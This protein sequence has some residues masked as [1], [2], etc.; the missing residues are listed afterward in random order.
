MMFG[1]AVW[2]STLQRHIPPE[3]LSRVSAYDWFGSLA[4][5]P[6]G[7]A[8]WGPVAAAIGIA[9]SLWLAFALLIVSALARARGQRHP[10]PQG[11][12]PVE[13]DLDRIAAG[14]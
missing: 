13:L 5:R 1:N 11:T 4:F 14:H 8:I 12:A 9:T 6:L 2:E 7:L 3:A 10:Q